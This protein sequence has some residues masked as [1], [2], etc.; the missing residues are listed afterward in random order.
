MPNP[1]PLQADDGWPRR[2]RTDE[3]AAY[4]SKVHGLPTEPKTMRNWRAA[5]RGPECRYFGMVPIYDRPV[6]DSF[7]E[8][9][10]LQDESPVARTR[11]LARAVRQNAA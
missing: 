8:N 1:E 9:D 6:L 3:A 11:R 10:A 7:A 2:M 4:L 5:G